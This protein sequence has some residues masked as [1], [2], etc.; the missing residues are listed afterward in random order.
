ME[1]SELLARSVFILNPA[2]EIVHIQPVSED[3]EEPDYDDA[4]S[5]LGLEIPA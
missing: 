1:R 5:A 4:M 2:V 3:S